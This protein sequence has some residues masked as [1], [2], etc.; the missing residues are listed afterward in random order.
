MTLLC[1]PSSF[2]ASQGEIV[3]TLA[4]TR[5][6]TSRARG[7]LDESIARHLLAQ[8]DLWRE[9]GGSQLETF[10]DWEEL[11][12]YTSEARLVL[13]AW[14]RQYRRDMSTANI[15]VS[16]ASLAVGVRLVNSLTRRV[17]PP[18]SPA[19]RVRGGAG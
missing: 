13:T 14:A 15:L 8:H 19:R 1:P 6:I 4:S 3:V 16:S 2:I 5:V 17:H 12:D 18:A 7:V 10:H 9:L 11:T